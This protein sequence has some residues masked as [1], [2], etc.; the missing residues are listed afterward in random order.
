MIM[1]VYQKSFTIKTQGRGSID[2]TKYVLNA[3][4]KSDINKGICQLFL[5][6]T[7]A[8]LILCEN[9]DPQVRRDLEAFMQTVVPDGNPLFRHTA[10]GPDDM[11]AHVR[12]VL[13]KNDIT[14]PIVDGELGL[15]TWQGIFL[16]E[17]RVSGHERRVTMTIMGVS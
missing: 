6:H 15:G 4:S 13:T 16:W 9:C 1:E 12:T 8:S 10:E 2:I 14:L 11:P 5:H 7:S 3:L 17:H